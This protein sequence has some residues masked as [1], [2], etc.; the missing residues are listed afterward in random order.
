MILQTLDQRLVQELMVIS[1]NFN[2]TRPNLANKH[3]HNSLPD[4]LGSP[5]PNA[6][7][8]G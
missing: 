6:W 2:S 8:F 7:I 1:G 4:Y 5:N 3:P